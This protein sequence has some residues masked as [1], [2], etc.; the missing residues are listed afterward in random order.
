MPPLMQLP[1]YKV[2]SLLDFSPLDRGIQQYKQDSERARRADV[3]RTA[4]NALMSG[5]Y[6]GAMG[7]ALAGDRADLA[8]V[9]MQA[10]AAD[11]HE[12]DSDLKRQYMQIDRMGRIAAAAAD[13]P[14]PANRQK[15]HAWLLSQHPGRDKLDPMYLDPNTGLKML[16]AEAGQYKSELEKKME[17]AKLGLMQAQTHQAYRKDEPEIFRIM[18]G[19]GIDPMSDEG[20]KIVMGKMG[21]ESPANVR[22]WQYY[23]QLGP[24]QQA[25]YRQ[26]RR[27]DKTVDTGTEFVNISNPAAPR[28]AKDVAGAASLK[29]QGKAQGQAAVELPA[30]LQRA[31]DALATIEKL[32]SHPGREWGTGAAGFLPGIPGTAQKDFVELNEQAKGGAFL[33]AFQLLKGG[34]AITNIEGDK[35][36]KAIA[37][38]DRT[39]TKQGYMDAL[40][41]LE[42]VI[43]SGAERARAKAQGIAP[44]Q[45]APVPKAEI[46]PGVKVNSVEEAMALPPGTRFVTPD[47]REK[48]R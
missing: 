30:V 34:G 48:I 6:K 17:V 38:L 8:G 47:G 21:G 4:G 2:N 31:D 16:A 43:R 26:M 7:T 37:R 35:A 19:A 33:Q 11:S 40:K 28:I 41:D 9:A 39:Q 23:N 15:A 3:A 29:E 10:R 46:A 20:R 12:K 25:A 24:D 5:D 14:N 1:E 42:A 27:A 13:D 32:R 36:T 45:Q 44:Q 18:K 22:E